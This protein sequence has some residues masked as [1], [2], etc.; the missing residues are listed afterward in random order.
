M[1]KR[2]ITQPD[3][4]LS[5]DRDIERLRQQLDIVKSFLVGKETGSSLADFDL[6]TEQMI[7]EV[8]GRSSEMVEAYAYAQLGE[9][10]SWVYLPQEAPEGGAHDTDQDA[11]LQRKRVLENCIA[12]LEARR[13]AAAKK[14]HRETTTVPRVA[15]YMSKAIRC[16]S[17]DATLK[18]AARL[19]QKWK[20]G[21]LLVEDSDEYIGVISETELSRE[22]VARGLDPSITRVKT[23]MREPIITI[24]A[25]D[26]IVEAVR[27]MKEKATRHLAVTENGTIIGVIS[28]SDLLRYYSG[29]F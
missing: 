29:V 4:R 10:T 27:L 24:A 2:T 1:G 20:V 22:V 19:L 18:E 17:I 28:V 3:R 7:S 25:G 13:A 9:A 11:L 8:L 12:D 21:S 16:V 14:Q 6:T 5:L 15:D 23:C 26:P